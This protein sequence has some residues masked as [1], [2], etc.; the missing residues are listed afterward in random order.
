MHK[1]V[2]GQRFYSFDLPT[3]SLECLEIDFDEYVDGDGSYHFKLMSDTN[4]RY[5]FLT[6]RYNNDKKIVGYSTLKYNI[7]GIISNWQCYKIRLP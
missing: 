2:L 4:P 7:A 1:T 6:A 3:L 5:C